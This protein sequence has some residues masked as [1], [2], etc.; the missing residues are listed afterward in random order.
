MVRYIRLSTQVYELQVFSSSSS[1]S[2]QRCDGLGSLPATAIFLVRPG[3][4]AE[5]DSP[6]V[7]ADDVK[8]DDVPN[9]KPDHVTFA[10]EVDDTPRS[11]LRQAPR[12]PAPPGCT[13]ATCIP[14]V[15][16]RGYCILARLL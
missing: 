7:K 11:E 2:H 1:M 12:L 6:N 3:S 15:L 5:D 4:Q 16:T 14:Q 9:V 13:D 8:E 10:S